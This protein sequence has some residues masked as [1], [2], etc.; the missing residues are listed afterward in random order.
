VSTPSI[1]TV[2]SS[3]LWSIALKRANRVDDFPDPVL[4]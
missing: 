1:S 2:P 3:R 4:V